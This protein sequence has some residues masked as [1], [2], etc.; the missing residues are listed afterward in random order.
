MEIFNKKITKSEIIASPT[1]EILTGV[2]TN[3]EKGVLKEF[4]NEGVQSKFDNLDQETLKIYFECKFEDKIIKGSD[5]LAY[6]EKP[7]SNSKLGKFLI[8]YDELNVGREIK[9]VFDKN[10]FG[11]IK[12]D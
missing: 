9:V 4:L 1:D 8:K 7:M 12:V 10:S 5:R 6:Y 3:I 11:K 2:I